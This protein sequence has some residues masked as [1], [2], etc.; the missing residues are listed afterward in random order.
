MAIAKAA[1]LRMIKLLRTVIA[2]SIYC[3]AR[4]VMQVRR[5]VLF[6]RILVL[7]LRGP[8]NLITGI[9]TAITT[10]PRFGESLPF[11]STLKQ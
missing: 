10:G 8:L 9:L 6:E 2:K 1:F 5:G 7:R 11:I 3:R 4:R